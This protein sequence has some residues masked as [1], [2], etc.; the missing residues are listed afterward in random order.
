[1]AEYFTLQADC[2]KNYAKQQKGQFY[3]VL[4]CTILHFR[5]GHSLMFSIFLD[6]FLNQ[7]Y[8]F[9][10]LASKSNSCF[11]PSLCLHEPVFN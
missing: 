2:R 9:K 6:K 1:M 5:D 3:F 11:N 4:Y 7:K 8:N 10:F